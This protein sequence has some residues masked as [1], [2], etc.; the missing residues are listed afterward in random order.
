MKQELN[1][2]IPAI[3]FTNEK[4]L[5]PLRTHREDISV[6]EPNNHYQIL[7]CRP[8]QANAG[9]S[10]PSL[11]AIP[12]EELAF[13]RTALSSHS[14]V[15]LLADGRA[16]LILGELL[17]AS[18]V[19]LA[20]RPQ[21]SPAALRRYAESCGLG[22]LVFSPAFPASA[23]SLSEEELEQ[24]DELNYYLGQILT[25]RKEVGIATLTWRI[26][27]FVG[28]RLEE[29]K[30]SPVEDRLAE[31]QLKRLTAYLLC[32]FLHLRT[33]GGHTATNGA[34]MTEAPQFRYGVEYVDP[35]ADDN[36]EALLLFADLPFRKLPAFSDFII[37]KEGEKLILDAHLPLSSE[38]KGFRAAIPSLF[39]LRITLEQI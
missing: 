22:D 15:A 16:V 29:N 28:C 24:M 2:Y 18:G 4:A 21:I 20:V 19:L 3:D 11:W 36:G 25:P 23:A 39:V 10:L 1:A 38:K 7:A 5:A 34:A 12:D 33:L 27:N 8:H 30:L 13:L 9:A 17:A 32:T 26:A 14:R 37:R 35:N 31:G 6:I